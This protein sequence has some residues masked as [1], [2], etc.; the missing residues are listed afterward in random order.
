VR[1]AKGK[2]N[3]KVQKTT[4]FVSEQHELAQDT[5]HKGPYFWPGPKESQTV[6]IS[7]NNLNFF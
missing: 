6:K 4:K 7:T 1:D 2:T 3:N 5:K